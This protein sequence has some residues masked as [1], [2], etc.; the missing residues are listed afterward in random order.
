MNFK[1]F[2]DKYEIFLF[3][4]FVYLFSF[5][6]IKTD[7]HGEKKKETVQEKIVE[8]SEEKKEESVDEKKE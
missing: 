1:L 7:G 4:S 3:F 5:E 8:T 6:S 2:G